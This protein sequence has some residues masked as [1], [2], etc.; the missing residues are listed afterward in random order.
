MD[1]KKKKK[2]EKHSFLYLLSWFN[3]FGEKCRFLYAKGAERPSAL[4]IWAASKV[5]QIAFVR[6]KASC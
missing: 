4:L 5:L 1:L 3:F 6:S 2:E